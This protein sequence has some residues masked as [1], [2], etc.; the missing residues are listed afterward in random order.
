VNYSSFLNTNL[1]R[2]KKFRH[3]KQNTFKNKK[4]DTR[5]FFLI[6]T[7]SAILLV[8]TASLINI[9]INTIAEASQ[10]SST[11]PIEATPITQHIE[12]ELPQKSSLLSETVQNTETIP[13]TIQKEV[14]VKRPSII[15][16]PIK[17]TTVTPKEVISKNTTNKIIQT[18]NSAVDIEI[19]S[20]TNTE[21]T[22][23]AI[24]NPNKS[25][26]V[27]VKKGDTLSAIFRRLSIDAN[28]LYK[29]LHSG[30]QANRLVH[31][32]PGQN[33][34]ITLTDKNEFISLNYNINKIESLFIDRNPDSNKFTSNITVKEIDIKKQ[35]ATSTIKHSL[36]SAGNNAGLSN[37]MI[38]KLAHIFGWDIDFALDIRKGDSFSVLYEEK[39]LDNEKI[40]DGNILSAEFINRGKIFTAIRYTDASGHTDYYSAQGLSMRKAFLRSPVDFS[41]ISSRFST[42]RKHPVL[43]RIRAHK[44][45]DYAASRG[46]PIK[47]VGDG[48]VIFKGRKGGYG[49]VVILQHGSK[50]TTLYAH[51]NSY[52]RKIRRGKQVKQGQ[53]IGYVGSSGL[54][55]GPHLH[56]EFRINGVHRNPLTV[57]LPSAA[58]IARKYRNDF[59]TVADTLISQLKS[60]KVKTIALSEQ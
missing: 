8:L 14:I 15:Q 59:Q 18:D 52:N 53:I 7:V 47:A 26:T 42:G 55:T 4:K 51:M 38:M 36:F 37:T 22:I 40:G 30:A 24:T 39:Y 3:K 31:I 45:V 25:Q 33:F 46:T 57:P 32:K 29:I 17:S 35:F 10:T 34:I 16:T 1:N 20:S 50:Y 60:R 43:N 9:N 27:I 41:R 6:S 2:N 12:I 56:Y 28:T 21:K 19:I 5:K 48:K 11:K 58:P 23:T 13:N 44:G 54:A 49:R